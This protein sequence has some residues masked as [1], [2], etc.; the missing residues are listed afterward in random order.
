MTTFPRT[1]TLGALLLLAVTTAACSTRQTTP[2][3]RTESGMASMAP[4]L[5]VERFLQAANSR[6]Y[7]AMADLFGT[8]QGAVDYDRRTVEREME[9]I[10]EI[11][12]HEDYEVTSD[13]VAP[14]REHPTNRVGVNIRKD[15]RLI[16]D[17]AFLV[18][19]SEGGAWLVEEIDLEKVTGG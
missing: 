9:L 19:Q 16:P 12:Q 6:N 7:R 18:V 14:G 13:R 1:R 8:Y 10:S 4:M 5:S 11:L 2:E 3:P 15:G 17:V